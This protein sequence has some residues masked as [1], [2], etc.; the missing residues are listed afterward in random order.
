MKVH[1]KHNLVS[2]L[3]TETW[4]SRKQETSECL[5]SEKGDH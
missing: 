1:D 2:S 4:K 3:I 5:D